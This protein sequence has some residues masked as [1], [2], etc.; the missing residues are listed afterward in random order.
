MS[1]KRTLKIGVVCYPTQG[2]SGIVAVEIAHKMAERGHE[3]HVVSYDSPARL[4]TLR[5]R[6]HFHPVRV[7]KYP[8]FEY[9]PYSMALAA[10]LAEV[11]SRYDLDVLHVHYALP[12][13]SSAWM[14]RTIAGREHLPIVTTLHGTDITIVG[15]DPSYLTVTKFSVEISDRV[16]AVSH[17]LAKRVNEVV[18]TSVE[19]DVVYNFVDSELFRPRDSELRQKIRNGADAP[20]LIHMSNFRPVKRIQD[21]VETFLRVRAEIPAKLVMVGDGPD[22]PEAEQRL[23]ASEWADD[24]H[25]LGTQSSAEEILPLGDLFM[26]PTNAESFGLAALEAMSCGLPV[27]GANVGGL[28][29]VVEDG[30][31]GHLYPPGD[32]DSM[33]RGVLKLLTDGERFREMKANARKRARETFTPEKSIG[34]YEQIYFEAIEQIEREGPRRPSGEVANGDE[35]ASTA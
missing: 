10:Q 17:W 34:R 25:F 23:L 19:S 4:N 26:M 7:P 35:S 3:V 1:E 29:E 5:D 9:P 30:I 22:R 20:V 24:V 15:N 12:H 31:S 18:G 13:A 14:A 2:G 11:I 8:L 28:P 16:T 27:I 6:V 33:A 21:V 32:V